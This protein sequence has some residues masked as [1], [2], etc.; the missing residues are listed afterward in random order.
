MRQAI[1]TMA[2]LKRPIGL[3]SI[4]Q[5]HVPSYVSRCLVSARSSYDYRASIGA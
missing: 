3:P 5:Q 4:S 1:A 2:R